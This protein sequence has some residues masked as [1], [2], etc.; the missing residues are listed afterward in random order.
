MTFM[1][2]LY[3]ATHL[4]GGI[5]AILVNI[6]GTGGAAATTLDGYP[7]AQQGKGQQALMLCFFASVFGGLISS[8]ITMFAMPYLARIGYYIHS[9][10][11]VVVILF[12]LTLSAVIA[13]PDKLKGLIA[14]FFVL[15]LGAL[16][17]SPLMSDPPRPFGF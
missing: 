1:I 14:G 10:E 7:M 5:P 16:G 4:G 2:A 17:A 6:P 3:C 8:I 12:G 15:M 11:M 9:V 13:S